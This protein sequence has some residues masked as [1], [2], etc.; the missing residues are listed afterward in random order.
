LDRKEEHNTFTFNYVP[1]ARISGDKELFLGW[2]SNHSYLLEYDSVVSTVDNITPDMQGYS[3]AATDG[4]ENSA[5]E[6]TF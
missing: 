6:H 2:L 1:L 4:G 3:P 5:Y